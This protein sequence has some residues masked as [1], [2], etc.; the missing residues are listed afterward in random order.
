V[1]TLTKAS[2]ASAGGGNGA[3]ELRVEMRTQYFTGHR[4]CPTG[5]TRSERT[6]PVKRTVIQ[7][8]ERSEDGCPQWSEDVV[9]RRT[10]YCGAI[11]CPAWRAFLPRGRRTLKRG[12]VPEANRYITPERS[13]DRPSEVERGCWYDGGHGVA[14]PAE[15]HGVRLGAV[16]AE[17]AGGR[18]L[19]LSGSR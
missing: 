6:V 1:T 19:F 2:A 10:P 12:T 3:S 11:P 7:H 4:S 13:K 16:L 15:Q 8:P 5:G 14:E 17:G 9:Y 18:P